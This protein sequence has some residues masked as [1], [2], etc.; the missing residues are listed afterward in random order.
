MHVRRHVH[1]SLGILMIPSGNGM[2]SARHSRDKRRV[3]SL[4]SSF[5]PFLK[6]DGEWCSEEAKCGQTTR[7]HWEDPRGL[8]WEEPCSDLTAEE[9]AW[10][11]ANWVPVFSLP[12]LG[13]KIFF[14]QNTASLICVLRESIFFNVIVSHLSCFI[15]FVIDLCL[16]PYCFSSYVFIFYWGSAIKWNALHICI[17]IPFIDKQFRVIN[18]SVNAIYD[19]KILINGI[20]SSKTLRLLICSSGV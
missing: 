7:K 20:F 8:G 3:P 15:L 18:H 1:I 5:S 9:E 14:S 19:V 11:G 10:A 17:Q 16:Y 6:K 4:H 2:T 12:A 13:G